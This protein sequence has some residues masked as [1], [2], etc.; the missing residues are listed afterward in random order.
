MRDYGECK[1][2]RA[3]KILVMTSTRTVRSSQTSGSANSYHT[4]QSPYEQP[5]RYV[6]DI[7][8]CLVH[9]RR[10]RISWSTVSVIEITL[11]TFAAVI[12][13]ALS[14]RTLRK[15]LSTDD[16]QINELSEWMLRLFASLILMQVRSIIS[17]KSAC[18][19]NI[20]MVLL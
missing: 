12:F 1:A 4:W 6:G 20:M 18:G 2:L 14:E 15:M 7:F 19:G 13:L 8:P 5:S 10:F 9:P 16:S 17:T 3:D 11:L